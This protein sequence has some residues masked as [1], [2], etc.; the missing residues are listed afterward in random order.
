[1]QDKVNHAH[2]DRTILGWDVAGPPNPDPAAEGQPPGA[3]RGPGSEEILGWDLPAPPPPEADPEPG[4]GD[5]NRE[6]G[7]A[8]ASADPARDRQILG[9]D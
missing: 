6:S 8:A 5:P 7:P 1:M 4:T 2:I 9:W 3:G